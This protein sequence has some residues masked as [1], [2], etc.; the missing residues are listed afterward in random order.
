MAHETR[1]DNL[2]KKH[3]LKGVNKPKM[4]PKHPK[5]KAI[6]LAQIGHKIKLIRFGV[7]GM[8]HNY[9]PEARRSFKA[10][11]AANIRK[12]KMSAAY[13]ADKFLWSG[14]Q[15]RKKSPPKSQRK[16]FG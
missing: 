9:S 6:V 15:G 5:K 3:R 7:Q 1:K 8:G 14:P 4:T 11:H 12:G 2:L 13:W 16:K 10:R